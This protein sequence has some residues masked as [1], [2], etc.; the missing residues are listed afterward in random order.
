M[1]KL[2]LIA[3]SAITLG[4]TTP[5]S[6]IFYGSVGVASTTDFEI[7]SQESDGEFGYSIAVGAKVPLLPLRAEIETFKFKGSNL[8]GNTT[9]DSITAN[10]I[11][12]NVYA[13]IPITIVSPYVGAGYGFAE[14]NLRN[15]GG[16][17][18]TSSGENKAYN[19]MA[20]VDIDVPLIPVGFSIEYRFTQIE[21]GDFGHNGDGEIQTIMAKARLAF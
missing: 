1:K 2:S 21:A 13:G 3:L 4:L 14:M 9:H 19:L 8:S 16:G 18:D 10:G 17:V 6:A 15:N 11:M 20:G 5:S 7:G 12:A